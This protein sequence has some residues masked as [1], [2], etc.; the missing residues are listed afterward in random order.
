M[1]D[2]VPLDGVRLKIAPD[3]RLLIS[4]KTLAEESR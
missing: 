3:S 1:F 2:G 4:G